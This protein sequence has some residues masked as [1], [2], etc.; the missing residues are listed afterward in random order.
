MIGTNDIFVPV[1]DKYSELSAMIHVSFPARVVTEKTQTIVGYSLLIAGACLLLAVTLL[2]GHLH[3][4]N[5]P[6]ARLIEAIT[7]IRQSG[8]NA[9]RQV[10]IKSSDEFGQVGLAFNEMIDDLNRRTVS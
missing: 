5:R 2:V 10:Q 9:Y 4:V 3:L 1:F 7:D 8:T 6:L